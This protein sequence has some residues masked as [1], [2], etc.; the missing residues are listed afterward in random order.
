ME[1][2]KPSGLLLDSHEYRENFDEDSSLLF[3]D[4]KNKSVQMHDVVTGV[5]RRIASM[6]LHRPFVVREDVGLEE[7]SE[8][9]ESRRFTFIS[10][11][12]EA[13]N[14][15]LPQGLVCPELQFFLL[16]N[17]DNP[18]LNIH[19]PITYFQ[20][21]KNLKVLDLSGSGFTT[22]P[23]ALDSLENLRTLR[24]CWCC[25]LVDIAL[26]GKLKKLEVLSLEGS[27]IQQLPDEMVQ[28]SNLRLLDLNNCRQLKVVPQNV[29]SNLSRL[30]C[31]SMSCS[32]TK[33]AMEGDESNACLSELNHLS[34]LTTLYIQIADAELLP[35]DIQFEKLTRYVIIVGHLQGS[36]TD[37]ALRLN[38]INRSLHLRNGISRL[39][40]RSKELEF[41][42]LS[43]T[44]FVLHPLDRESF[45]ELKHLR[46]NDSPEIQYI[47]DSKDQRFMQLGAFPL[48]ESLVLEDMENLEEVWHG[49]I[50]TGS[51]GSLKTLNVFSCSK[52]SYLLLLS[53]AEGLS[54]LENLSI[55]SCKTMQQIIAYER[56]SKVKEDEY[57]MT[58]LQL[59]PN[60]RKLTLRNLPRLI[61]FFSHKVR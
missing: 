11:H 4:S 10:L 5:A 20:G 23:S 13:V 58:N 24:L 59:F 17:N 21:M 6:D 56:E 49:Q 53:M 45:L 48:L 31:L 46:V 14:Y 41:L 36:K 32:F 19:I 51:F 18:S 35:K 40:E 3:M 55:I 42:K 50:P 29:L 2:L 60:L 43:G 9:D 37:R 30:E 22:L 16:H 57:A 54:K 47:I 1:I 39:L 15:Q 8:T 25:N 34:C 26:I 12:C 28:L 27:A 7:W 61:N 44:K 52:L 38:K 33:W